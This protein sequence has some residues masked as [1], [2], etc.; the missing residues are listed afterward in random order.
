MEGR[1]HLG[2]PEID[3]MMIMMMI[4]NRVLWWLDSSQSRY[5]LANM[6]CW[7]TITWSIL[8]HGAANSKFVSSTNRLKESDTYTALR[9]T[10]I[11]IFPVRCIGAVYIGH[12]NGHKYICL[13]LHTSR[14]KGYCCIRMHC[15]KRGDPGPNTGW[16]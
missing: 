5:G 12:F 6:T 11:I 14:L 2:D 7:V 4:L 16:T 9:R 8:L 13:W 1:D 10:N 15:C 3:G